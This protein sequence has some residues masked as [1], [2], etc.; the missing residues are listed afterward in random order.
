MSQLLLQI[1]YTWRRVLG[2]RL[3]KLPGTG[4]HSRWPRRWAENRF[5][6]HRS[7]GLALTI[8]H[9]LPISLIFFPHQGP[10][11]SLRRTGLGLCSSGWPGTHSVD[12][13]DLELAEIR[14]P[15]SSECRD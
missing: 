7:P 15:L 6:K 12:H 3:T 4:H 13:A 9:P 1:K 5:Y 8:Y 2:E 14:L 10:L 11:F